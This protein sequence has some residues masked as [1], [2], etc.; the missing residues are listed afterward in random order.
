MIR[1]IG[2]LGISDYGVGCLLELLRLGYDVKFVTEKKRRS[3]H[4]TEARSKLQTVILNSKIKNLGNVLPGDSLLLEESSKVDLCIIGGYD[5]IV[6][7][8]LLESPKYGVINT[9][10]GLIPDNRGCNPVMWAI[11]KNEPQ[12][13]TT[14]QVTKD[15]DLGPV[16]NKVYLKSQDQNQTSQSVYQNLSTDAPRHLKKSINLVEKKK[17][18]EIPRNRGVYHSA[19]MP[20]D[21]YVSW[22]WKNEFIQ[23]FS[24]AMIFPPYKPASSRV[25]GQDIFLTVIETIDEK[26]PYKPGEVIFKEHR[27]VVVSTKQGHA[28][29]ELDNDYSQVKKGLTLDS[30]SK[31]VF[32]IPVEFWEDFLPKESYGKKR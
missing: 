23:R 16:I 13:F 5:G 29:C 32:A 10:F 2:I 21:C 11:L 18:C 7:S 17:Y 25:L 28:V 27:K 8:P 3:L 24:N 15:I 20:N 31:G 26:N 9:H 19:G 12:G 6:H 22:K 1:S 14:Y 4:S 30:V